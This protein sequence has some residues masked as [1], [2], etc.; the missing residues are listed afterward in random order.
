MGWVGVSAQAPSDNLALVSTSTPHYDAEAWLRG[1]E[2]FPA[3]AQLVLAKNGKES[4][5]VA[6]FLA[7]ADLN[8]SFDG[9]RILFAGKHDAKDHWDVW[10]V[11]LTGGE[12]KRITSCDSDCVRPFYL[13]GER[14]VYAHKVKG[15]FV[16]ETATLDGAQTLHLTYAP[17][18]ALPTDVLR[19]GRILFEA[20]YP[21][22]RGTSPEIY[23]V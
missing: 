20:V 16:L 12:P 18:N 3:G 21:M 15:N 13:A 8:V 7:T 1:G 22:G 14:L 17:G 4:I 19:D 9:T 2:R 11:A 6:G 10:E 5:L 23:T